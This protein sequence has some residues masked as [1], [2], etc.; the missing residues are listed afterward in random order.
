MRAR[1]RQLGLDL[2][3]ASGKTWGAEWKDEI[4]RNWD[5]YAG[6][7]TE[8]ESIPYEDQF[9]DLDPNYRDRFGNP[10]LRLTFDWHDNERNLWRFVA[11]RAHEIMRAMNP[12]RIVEV[13]AG[14]RAVQHPRSTRARTRPAAA[15]WA[16]TRRTR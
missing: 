12:T 9:L 13:H 5:S 2:T 14:A 10:L 1:A 8:G 16:P 3:T 15:S 11:Q 4:R 7:V 6:I